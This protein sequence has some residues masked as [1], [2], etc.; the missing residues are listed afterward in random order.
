MEHIE[1]A[2]GRFFTQFQTN[3]KSID[4]YSLVNMLVNFS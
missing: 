3:T 1:Q 2:F 4:I